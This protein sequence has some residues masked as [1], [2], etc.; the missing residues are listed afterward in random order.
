M[1]THFVLFRVSDDVGIRGNVGPVTPPGGN[2][3][4]EGKGTD[5]GKV[6]R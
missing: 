2:V 5:K 1:G 3:A 6:T 4:G